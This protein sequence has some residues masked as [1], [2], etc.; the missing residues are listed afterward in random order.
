MSVK[1]QKLDELAAKLQEDE[2]AFAEIY[3][4]LLPRIY[5]YLLRRTGGKEV[6]EDL[7]SKTFLKVVENLSDFSGN[8]KAFTAWVYRIAQN[9]LIDHYRSSNSQ[10][11]VLFYSNE[12]L[13]R[14]ETPS[15]DDAKKSLQVREA[16]EEVIKMLS[17]LETAEQEILGL[18]F[19][20]E[21]DNEEIAKI[22]KIKK[23]AVA[24]RLHRAMQKLKKVAV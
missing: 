12:D 3:D 20:D 24:V 2:Q 18:K 6:A 9:C 15:K 13:S 4:Y 19:L 11:K 17:L 14:L 22:L 5:N 1:N 23:N 8:A 21:L 7:S 16:K 10:T